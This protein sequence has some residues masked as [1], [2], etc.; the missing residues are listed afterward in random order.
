MGNAM[1]RVSI[2]E[3]TRA[4]G[5]SRATVDRAL[6]GRG[7]VHD[8]T[9]QVIEE[10]LQRLSSAAPLSAPAAVGPQDAA[11]LDLVMRV[12][13]GMVDQMRA[14]CRAGG[15]PTVTFHDMYQASEDDL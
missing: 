2:G 12:G 7:H 3:L 14:S 10:T 11:G 13:R 1:R 15:A 4:T 6:N 9:R 5:L 8:R